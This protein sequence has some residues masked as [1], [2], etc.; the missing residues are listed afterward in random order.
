MH[1]GEQSV[2][3]IRLLIVELALSCVLVCVFGCGGSTGGGGTGPPPTQIVLSGVSPFNAVHEGN[4]F[5]V[6]GD[7]SFTLLAGGTGFTASS[8]IRWNGSPLPTTYG[9][10]TD[11]SATVSS[12]L[13]AAP[14]KASIVIHDS[15]SGVTSNAV[16]FGIAS[17]G[18]TSAG[19]VQMISVAPDGSP[20]NDDNLV[21]PSI[22]RT[23]R[24][25]AFQSAAT[26]LAPGPASGYQEI[27]ERDTCIGAPEGC[28]LSTIRIT[29]TANGSAVNGHSKFSSIS[30]DGRYVAFT[31]SATNILPNTASCAPP[32]ACIF[33]RSTCAGAT[34]SCTTSTAQIPSGGLFQMTPDGRYIAITGGTGSLPG[35][36]YPAAEVALW[37]TCNGAPSGCTPNAI[38]ISESSSGSPADQNPTGATVS[39]TGRYVAFGD[40]ASNLGKQNENRWPGVFLRDDCIGAAS[41]CTPST[42]KIDDAPDGSVANGAGGEAG[43]PAVSVDGRFVAFDSSAMNLVTPNLSACSTSGTPPQSCGYTFLRDTCNGVTTGCTPSTS[44][45]SLGNDGSV[46]DASAADQESMSADGRFVAFASLANNIVPGDTFPINGW[47]DIFVRDTCFGAPTGCNP[48]TVR[49]SVANYAGNFATESNAINDYPRISGDG[50]YIVFI[51]A[52]TNYLISGGNGHTMVYLAKTG[53]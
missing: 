30:A 43:N 52:A 29:V 24:F 34:S 32:S 5:A 4:G 45:V 13:I 23:G 46:P 44:I 8:V 39:T 12:A 25:V 49:V 16:V 17:P 33:L 2:R 41:G 18:A 14:G 19:V 36:P 10:S 26:N 50:H 38:L 27:Y 21:V 40:W 20:A 51:S 3:D 31:S 9:D 48:S 11:L 15:A 37:D 53:F 7:P 42:I 6:A 28:T 22:S 35:G 1:R 47:K